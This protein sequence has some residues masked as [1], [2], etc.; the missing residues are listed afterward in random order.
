M[1]ALEPA[2]AKRKTDRRQRPCGDGRAPSR[3]APSA[4]TFPLS[5]TGQP[6]PSS[7]AL[8]LPLPSGRKLRY[9]RSGL[10][11]RSHVD[12]HH[13]AEREPVDLPAVASGV[14]DPG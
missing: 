3:T 1:T 12:D 14:L 8:P 5:S 4:A 7:T 2:T 6:V 13:L 10:G 11:V 9:E